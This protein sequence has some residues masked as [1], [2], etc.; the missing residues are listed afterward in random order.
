MFLGDKV[1]TQIALMV[2][3]EFAWVDNFFAELEKAA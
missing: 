1:P 3:S 2:S